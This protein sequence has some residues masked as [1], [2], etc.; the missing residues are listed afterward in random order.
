[1]ALLRLL[2]GSS[3][4]SRD[5]AQLRTLFRWDLTQVCSWPEC[6]GKATSEYQDKVYCPR[7]LLKILQQ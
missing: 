6:S 7:H 4:H 3:A 5:K 1:M 2:F